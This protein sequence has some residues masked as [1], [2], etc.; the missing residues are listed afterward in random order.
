MF[1]NT[2]FNG[3]IMFTNIVFIFCYFSS[4]TVPPGNEGNC[5]LISFPGGAGDFAD[6]KTERESNN[7]HRDDGGTDR[8]SGK[9][10]DNDAGCRADHRDNRGTNR[11]ALE[12]AEKPHG[13]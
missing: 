12:A 11:H 10:R 9:D 3:K 4:G 8:S 5:P 13:R 6:D 1:P 7:I 2:I